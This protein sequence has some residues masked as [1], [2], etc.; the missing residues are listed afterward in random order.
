MHHSIKTDTS[1]VHSSTLFKLINKKEQAPD[2][3]LK[4]E[5]LCLKLYSIF[6]FT[7]MALNFKESLSFNG[8]S[9]ND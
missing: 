3:K 4:P 1:L 7:W 6:Y 5:N 9:R 8:Q 2:V